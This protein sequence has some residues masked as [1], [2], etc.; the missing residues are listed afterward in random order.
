E[1]EQ[2][3]NRAAERGYGSVVAYLR[4]LVAADALVDSLRNDWQDADDTPDRI[5]ASF[6]ESWHDAMTGKVQ[7]VESLW[8]GWDDDE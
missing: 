6:R 4:A 1:G 3:A 5:E 8:E 7:P 2:I